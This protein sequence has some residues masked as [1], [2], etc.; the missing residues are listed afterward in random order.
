MLELVRDQARPFDRKRDTTVDLADLRDQALVLFGNADDIDM[1]VARRHLPGQLFQ[2]PRAERIDLGD[3]RHVDSQRGRL[4][5]LQ[6][7]RIRQRLER[8][9]IRRDPGAARAE[10]D[11]I[12]GEQSDELRRGCQLSLLVHPPV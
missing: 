9:R 5:K 3:T 10:F 1:P 6:C 8:S 7:G 4:P 12:S 2:Q 11:R